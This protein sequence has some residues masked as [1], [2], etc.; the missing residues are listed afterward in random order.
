MSEWVSL[1]SVAGRVASDAAR[2]M[3]RSER[4]PPER[5]RRE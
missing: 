2:A 4:K 5:V 1:G 3:V